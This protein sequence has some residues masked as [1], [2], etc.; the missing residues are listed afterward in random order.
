MSIAHIAFQEMDRREAI[1]DRA[2][3]I[4]T[5]R[6][7]K[8]EIPYTT[9]KQDKFSYLVTCHYIQTAADDADWVDAYVHEDDVERAW[10]DAEQELEMDL[11]DAVALSV[12]EVL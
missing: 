12:A 8:N 2:H 3:D 9:R 11:M 4:L 1:A 5:H 6:C 10:M 7:E